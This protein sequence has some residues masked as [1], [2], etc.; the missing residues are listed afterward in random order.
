MSAFD[1]NRAVPLGAV[2]LFR[3]TSFFEQA[4]DALRARHQARATIRQLSAL[5]DHN[6]QDVG[7]ER[8]EIEDVAYGLARRSR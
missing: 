6:L 3:I 2:T 4:G 8:G 7:V 1:Q 5:S